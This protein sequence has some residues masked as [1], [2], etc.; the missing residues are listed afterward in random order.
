MKQT[1]IEITS[2]SSN[3]IRELADGFS[4]SGYEPHIEATVSRTFML[5]TLRGSEFD[6]V[7]VG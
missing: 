3:E 1:Q 5:L 4:A 2:L 7:E 6:D